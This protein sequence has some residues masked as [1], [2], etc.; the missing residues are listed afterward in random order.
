MLADVAAADK[1]PRPA[2]LLLTAEMTSLAA[3]RDS[4]HPSLPCLLLLAA[5]CC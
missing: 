2:A 3:Y 1:W 5:A 4:E